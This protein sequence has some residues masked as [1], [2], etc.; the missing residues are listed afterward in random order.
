M[1]M[2]LLDTEQSYVESL[3]TLM[4]VRLEAGPGPRAA[5][6]RLGGCQTRGNKPVCGLGS[7]AGRSDPGTQPPPLGERIQGP[8]EAGPGHPGLCSLLVPS[9]H[10]SWQP[11]SEL[12]S[13][14]H[15]WC[16]PTSI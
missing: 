11:G 6:L 16:P 9:C 10:S 5:V 13:V 3:R 7:E 15:F 2:T 14:N 8:S 1:T 12:R 4:Q